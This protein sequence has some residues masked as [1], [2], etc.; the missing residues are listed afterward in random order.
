[1]KAIIAYLIGMMTI[2]KS[3]I[4][5]HTKKIRVDCTPRARVYGVELLGRLSTYLEIGCMVLNSLEVECTPRIKVYGIK[6]SGLMLNIIE[7]FTEY[8]AIIW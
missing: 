5:D 6:L 7:G 1:M 8:H 2:E 3:I 4:L